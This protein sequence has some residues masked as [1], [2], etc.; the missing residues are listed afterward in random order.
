MIDI[1]KLKDLISNNSVAELKKFITDNNLIIKDGKIF[2]KNIEEVRK[3]SEYFDRVQHSKKIVL[4]SLY[5]TLLS[6]SSRF[7][8]KRIGQSVTLS[9]RLIC[10]HMSAF[11]NECITG[12]YDYR[13]EAVIYGD[14]DSVQFSA[15]STIKD[16]VESGEMEW[17]KDIAVNLYTAIGDKVCESFP[18]FMAKA[19][20][21]PASFGSIIKAPCESVGTRG[22]YITK[23]RYAILNYYNKGIRIDD[24]PKL[25][26]MGL[27]L[28]RSDTPEICQKF[29]TDVLMDLLKGGSED[30]LIQ[31]IK[32][33]KEIFNN[34]PAWERGTP[35]RVNKLT[36]YAAELKAGKARL[37]GHVRA[38]INWNTLRSI[39][40]DNVHSRITDGMKILVCPLRPNLMKMTSI[41]YPIDEAHLPDWFT[42]LP[43]DV[44]AMEQ[45]VVNK[46]LENLFSRLPFWKNIESALSNS[47]KLFDFFEISS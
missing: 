41:A 39:N 25:K 11:V 7:Y 37:P 31:K 45:S 12:E 2:P 23:K 18:G 16:R 9:G 10:Q 8:D 22:I 19:F 47:S 38:A 42:S 44:E 21:C 35:R 33:F 34:L 14:T 1:A 27:D 3:E 24:H 17:N 36:K 32:N 15:W 43:F 29:L 20:H 30:T 5:G 6:P 13:G 28:R 4:N 26:A 40:K 46:K